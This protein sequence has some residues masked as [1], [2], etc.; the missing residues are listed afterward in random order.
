[1]RRWRVSLPAVVS[2][3]GAAPASNRNHAASPRR[4]ATRM[5]R[6]SRSNVV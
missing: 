1:M 4:P 3:T 6:S 5:R 2:K